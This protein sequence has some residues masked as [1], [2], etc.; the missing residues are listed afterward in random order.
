MS[1]LVKDGGRIDEKKEARLESSGL[2]TGRG[3]LPALIFGVFSYIIFLY[4][5]VYA[6]GFV[7][8]MGVPKSIDSGV[9]ETFGKALLV[10]FFLILLFGLQHSLMA[11]QGFKRRWKQI[12]PPAIERSTYVLLASLLLA[13]LFWQWRPILNPVWSL[14]GPVAR[15]LMVGLFWLGWILVLISSFMIDHFELF[16]LRQ[17]YNYWRGRETPPFQFKK[18]GPYRYIRHP[19]MLGFIMAFWA[20]P[21]MTLGH[22]IFAVSTTIYILIGIRFEERELLKTFGKEYDEYRREV[23][24]LLPTWRRSSLFRKRR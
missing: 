2:E 1:T 6:I 13:L 10:D 11:R 20:T 18:E 24:M 9:K 22:F 19:I 17:V 15:Y 23:P 12:I 7:G 4:V 3:R 14:E 16:G 5:F 8:N 21:G